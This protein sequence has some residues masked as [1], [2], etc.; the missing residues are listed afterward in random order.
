MLIG[1]ISQEWAR[2]ERHNQRGSLELKSHVERSRLQLTAAPQS[3]YL[4]YP[5]PL[6]IIHSQFSGINYSNLMSFDMRTA[7]NAA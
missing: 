4:D 6:V 2:F 1:S 5:K 3:R 7:F